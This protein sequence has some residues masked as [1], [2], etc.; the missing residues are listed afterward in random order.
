MTWTSRLRSNAALHDLPPERT[1]R[2]GRPRLKGG[3]LP[4]LA[5]I[6]ATAAFSQVTVTR[7][8]KT[9]T[10]AAAAFTCLWYSVAG[11]R[12]VTVVLIRDKPKTGYDLALVTTEE[13]TVIARVIERY[14]ARW[15]IEVAIEDAKQLFGTGQARNRTA[16]AVERTVPFMLACQAIAVTWYSAAGHSP[17][18]TAARRANA[19]WYTS[20]TEPSTADMTAKLRRVIIAAKFK[21]VHTDQPEPEEIHAIR[22]AWED[23]E[24][25]AAQ[26]TKVKILRNLLNNPQWLRSHG[27]TPGPEPLPAV[28][29]SPAA[30]ATGETAGPTY[31]PRGSLLKT[32]WSSPSMHVVNADSVEHAEIGQGLSHRI[33]MR[34]MRQPGAPYHEPVKPLIRK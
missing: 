5:K 1:G 10:I 3:R 29:G 33:R 30:P 24:D 25:L 21:R 11:T 19:P 15:A 26:T 2:K 6:A 8:G 7:Y 12:T 4:S 14:A 20:K 16:H 22:L 27:L 34:E 13:N 9:E 23:A 31:S 17:A 18:D 32:G 28:G